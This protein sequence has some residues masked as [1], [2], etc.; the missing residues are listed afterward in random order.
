[1][2][3]RVEKKLHFYGRFKN[4]HHRYSNNNCLQEKM[5]AS[6]RHRMILKFHSGYH[7]Y[8][9]TFMFQWMGNHQSEQLEQMRQEMD[10]FYTRLVTRFSRN[11][12]SAAQRHR[13][14]E[15]YLFPDAP[16]WGSKMSLTN[17]RINNGL[18]YHGVALVSPDA[19]LKQRLDMHMRTHLE[20][21]LKSPSKIAHID[22]RWIADQ[23][24]YVM[25]YGAKSIKIGRLPWE[26]MIV[27]P[28]STSE[29]HSR[30]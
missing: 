10:R 29:L 11:P 23:P 14:P 18:H 17:L 24:W 22:C 28:R 4:N 1:M 5:V 25:D 9:F 13:L 20:D 12:R 15:I 3:K 7:A 26:A 2:I 16:G 8:H 6:L 27:Y 19:R 21:Y 30:F